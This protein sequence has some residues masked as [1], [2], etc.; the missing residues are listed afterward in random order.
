MYPE[1]AKRPVQSN[2]GI[3]GISRT[4]KFDK[5]RGITYVSYSVHYKD[6]EGYPSNKTFFVGDA[7]MI[8]NKEEQ[9]ALRAAK[10]FRK[11]YESS[12]QYM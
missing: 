2:T 1:K 10:R 4:T 8:S 3:R 7:D 6:N 11:D 12:P 5:R 9:K